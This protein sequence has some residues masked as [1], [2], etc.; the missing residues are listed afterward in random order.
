MHRRTL[1]GR[2]AAIA[3][4]GVF[5]AAAATA[6]TEPPAPVAVHNV[7]LVHGLY[8]DGSSW[9]K[10][11]PLLQAQGL[12]VTSVQNPL[13]GFQDDVDAVKRVLA[14][15]DGPTLL[16][17]HSYAGMVISEAGTDPHVAGRGSTPSSTC[18]GA[19]ARAHK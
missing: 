12:H 15:Q 2:I 7:V 9:G 3:L 4:A 5:S 10:V 11:I 14:Q 17:G 19:V 18:T 13:S 8:A 1:M 16:V 6:Q